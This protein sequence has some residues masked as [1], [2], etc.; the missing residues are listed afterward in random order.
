[1]RTVAGRCTPFDDGSNPYRATAFSIAVT[2]GTTGLSAEQ[3]AP[4]AKN[5]VTAT[6]AL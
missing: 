1:V 2:L 4:K 6:P 3:I 5:A